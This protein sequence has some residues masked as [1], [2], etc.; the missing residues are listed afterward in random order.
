MGSQRQFWRLPALWLA[1][2]SLH[3]QDLTP[4]AYRITPVRSNAIT[5]TYSFSSGSIFTDLALPITDFKARSHVGIFSYYHSFSFFGRSANVTGSLPYSV[6]TFEARVRNTE[7]SLYR[8]GLA[9][10]RLR[11]SVNLLGAPAMSLREFADWRERTT[12]GVSLTVA[13]PTGQ[14]DP[15]RL[16]NAG[17][18]RWAAKPELGIA[19][20]WG[21][22][23]MDLYAGAWLYRDNTKFFPG[24]N[25]KGQTSVG[26]GEAHLTHN[27]TSR[28]WL[29]FDGNYWIGG[30]TILGGITKSDLQKNSRLGATVAIPLSGH[31]SLKFSYSA[32]SYITNGGDYQN[33]SVAWQ[34]SWIPGL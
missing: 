23:T 26:A 10:M 18:H 22:W 20:R 21:R 17:S 2:V 34:Y 15:A 31:Q 4:R 1:V 13:A 3:A 6:G 8:S 28:F 16:I 14:Y 27:L 12:V 33:V 32:G 24:S 9:D 29:S 7:G 11:L 5:L 30:R 25:T 19:K